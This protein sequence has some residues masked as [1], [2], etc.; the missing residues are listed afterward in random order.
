MILLYLRSLR[1]TNHETNPKGRSFIK[2]EAAVK[3]WK[4]DLPSALTRVWL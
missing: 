2:Q 3:R 1:E 4:R